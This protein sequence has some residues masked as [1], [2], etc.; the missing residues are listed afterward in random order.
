VASLPVKTPPQSRSRWA[1]PGLT[2]HPLHKI[3]ASRLRSQCPT[4]TPD[5][6][7][8]GRGVAKTE[9]T[10]RRLQPHH[11]PCRL[12]WAHPPRARPHYHHSSQLRRVGLR[13]SSGPQHGSTTESLHT[14]QILERHIQQF[15]ARPHMSFQ[16]SIRVCPTLSFATLRTPPH[17]LTT[18][19][20]HLRNLEP[21]RPQVKLDACR[22]L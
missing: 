15:R 6:G 5:Q 11:L 2:D 18:M 1:A 7:D 12:R 20:H 16:H 4:F 19:D 3:Q 8:G 14:R 9:Q 21:R 10:W 22:I 17:I 13:L